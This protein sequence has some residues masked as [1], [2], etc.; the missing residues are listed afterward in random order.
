MIPKIYF[1]PFRKR[2]I[3]FAQSCDRQYNNSNIVLGFSHSNIPS[4]GWNF[5]RI[6][7][8]GAPF[9][10]NQWFDYPKLG[11]STDGVFISGNIF[12]NNGGENND[13]IQSIVYQID[14]DLGYEGKEV[15]YRLWV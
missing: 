13:F 3:V 6:K 7:V 15:N 12:Q 1:D 8:S 14:K 4:D 5:Y 9:G 10:I 11:I 2:F